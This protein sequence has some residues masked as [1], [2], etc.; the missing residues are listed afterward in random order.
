MR[1]ILL[2][3]HF[4]GPLVP[5][6]PFIIGPFGKPKGPDTLYSN[7]LLANSTGLRPVPLPIGGL[8]GPLSTQSV[9]ATRRAKGPFIIKTMSERSER[10]IANPIGFY[11]DQLAG[12]GILRITWVNRAKPCY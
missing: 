7:V 2:G 9:L 12:S 4:I 11:G 5:K 8:Q 10:V 1:E 6:G 3:F